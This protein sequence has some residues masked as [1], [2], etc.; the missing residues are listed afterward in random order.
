MAT[1]R[2]E[3]WSGEGAPDARELRRQLEA[4]GYGV[5]EWSDAP[6][7]TYEPHAHAEDQSHWVVSGAI[8]LT[9]DGQEYMLRPGDRDYLPAGTVHSARVV[10]DAPVTYLIAAKCR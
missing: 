5:F 1:L 6:G 2:V 8:A 7:T 10:G 3:T 9:V 4:E